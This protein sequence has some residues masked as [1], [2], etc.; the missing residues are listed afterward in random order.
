MGAAKRNK[1]SLVVD[2][3]NALNNC[4]NSS[5]EYPLD[6]YSG[7]ISKDIPL[8]TQTYF[9]WLKTSDHH[10][11][12]KIKE[13][14]R[15]ICSFD[16]MTKQGNII[17]LKTSLI[18]LNLPSSFRYKAKQLIEEERGFSASGNVAYIALVAYC[19]EIMRTIKQSNEVTI[20]QAIY[21]PLTNSYDAGFPILIGDEPLIKKGMLEAEPL[22]NHKWEI[23]KNYFI[24]EPF[25]FGISA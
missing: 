10:I 15:W 13:L 25:Y 5:L 22:P 8:V 21:H 2:L 7:V 18:K 19:C 24:E 16:R 23:F 9:D 11:T 20:S 1:Q 3:I 14:E 4:N 6:R 17:N 12:L